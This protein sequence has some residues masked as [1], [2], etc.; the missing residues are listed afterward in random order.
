MRKAISV[1]L[2]AVMVLSLLT[3]LPTAVS[4][5]ETA[6]KPIGAFIPEDA[7]VA[8]SAEEERLLELAAD[9]LLNGIQG[10]T[11]LTDAEKAL[12]VHDRLAVWVDYDYYSYNKTDRYDADSYSRY[13]ALLKHKATCAGYS[14][15]YAY[16]MNKIGIET[17]YVSS[18]KLNHGWNIVVINN[19]PYYVDV[20]W[21][22]CTMDYIL[23]DNFLRSYNGIVETDHEADDFAT[24][25]KG[26]SITDTTYDNYY[27]R[28]SKSEF[29]LEDNKIYY[30]NH[31]D[32]K[33]KI[34]NKNHS[35][36]YTVPADEFYDNESRSYTCRT[37]EQLLFSY[38]DKVYRIDPKTD[39][40]IKKQITSLDELNIGKLEG[41]VDDEHGGDVGDITW[42]MTGSK[43]SL[44]GSGVLGDHFR[45]K[46]NGNLDH[47]CSLPPVIKK[48][49]A[50]V[51]M[52]VGITDISYWTFIF[53]SNLR[54]ITIPEGVTHIGSFAFCG[55]SNLKS[56]TI[57][58]SVKSI[59]DAVFSNCTSLTNV[60][61]TDLA[62]W[63]R[64]SF[65]SFFSNPHYYAENLYL[66]G[67]LITELIIP[68]GI[69]SIPDRM[70]YKNTNLKSVTIPK[71]VTKIGDYAFYGCSSLKGVYI[72]DLAA[73]LRV[74]F[75]TTYSTPQYYA[76]NLY[77]NGKLI[78]DLV[79]PNGITAIPG[80]MF[81]GNTD[82][83]S[84][85]IP[86]SVTSIGE[87]A[88]YGCSNL[89][90]VIIP[91][92]VTSIDN[93]A[94]S[95][96]CDIYTENDAEAERFA[97]QNGN[98][99]TQLGKTHLGKSGNW[100]WSLD[101]SFTLTIKGTGKIDG[102]IEDDGGYFY[103]IAP[104]PW[105]SNV[106]K[107]VIK[108][109]ITEIGS[110]AF[111]SSEP[112]T[113]VTIPDSVT[114]IEDF[115]FDECKNLKSVT[116]PAS[117]T[118]IGWFAFGFY[119]DWWN[120]GG[121]QMIDGFTIKGYHGTAAEQY[122]VENGFSFV[123]LD[124]GMLGD[125]NNDGKIDITDATLVQMIAAEILVPTDTQKLVGDVNNDGK[126][127]ITDATLIQMFA[128]E[129][130]FHF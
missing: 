39:S 32:G 48:I 35:V 52:P 26:L 69:T 89:K 42:E 43:L 85:T 101:S 116:I 61:I 55:C 75:T 6:D 22:D 108:N 63:L 28:D 7:Q 106:K 117:V 66:N 102:R 21:D 111:S 96:N 87:Y 86:K 110:Y 78:T 30:Y 122:A 10:N 37:N 44:K 104:A 68:D 123:P 16:L 83:N 46:E 53:Y 3:V 1:I 62:A 12:L 8:R 56:I 20:T 25:Y 34:A 73:W 58:K 18:P 47:Y 15:A 27:W 64:V 112:L 93:N 97:K 129:V 33:L 103:T 50:S 17:D 51:A 119:P 105:G 76:Q 88:F 4:A 114:V 74:S 120:M 81:Q 31:A 19:K 125:V 127:D 54:S 71:S 23:H 40:V 90:S 130:I 38:A 2:S 128:A 14:D 121:Y 57:P 82:L 41:A 9:K 100:S 92:S 70:F 72:S 49:V 80:H 59:D 77:L 67:K 5:E 13:G 24:S 11:K 36:I 118:E 84:V 94:F 109:G 115:A 29:L 113:S 65:S 60:Y 126:I 107:V 98:N 91:D 124:G 79:I 95:S 99:F 45:L